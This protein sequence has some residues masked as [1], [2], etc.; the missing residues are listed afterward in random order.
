M[1][2]KK[3]KGLL[4]K[5]GG[6]WSKFKQGA[7]GALGAAT[8]LAAGAAGAYGAGKLLAPDFT[9]GVTEPLKAGAK[10][11]SKYGKALNDADAAKAAAA[12]NPSMAGRTPPQIGPDNRIQ[13]PYAD[14]PADEEFDEYKKDDP[15]NDPFINESTQVLE[16]LDNLNDQDFAAANKNLSNIVDNHIHKN[17]RSSYKSVKVFDNE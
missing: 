8:G 3:I 10:L 7:A 15:D 16:F 12:A 6:F 14:M 5:K 1:S 17:V 11:A 2:K 13:D 4:E 9:R